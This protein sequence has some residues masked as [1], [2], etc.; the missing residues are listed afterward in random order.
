MFKNMRRNFT[1]FLSASAVVLLAASLAACSHK[2]FD[3]KGVITDAKDSVLYFENVGLDGPVTLDSVKLTAEGDFNFNEKAT[4]APEFYRLRIAGQ[5]INIAIDS[6]ETVEVKAA[7]PT[8]ATQYDVSGS[9]EN[10]KVKELALLQASLQQQID[11]I[12][13][14]PALGVEAVADSVGRVLA[15]YKDHIKRAYIYKEPMKAYA[16]FAL[17][18]T[19]T[20]GGTQSLIFDPRANEEDV[21]AFGAVATSWDTYYPKAVRGQ[22]LHNIA[23]EGMKNIRIIRAKMNQTLDPGRIDVSGVIDLNLQDNHGVYRRLSSLKGSVVLLDFHLFADKNS[24]KRIMKLREIYNKYHAQGLEIYQVS[25][26]PDEHFWKTQVAALPW[27][28]V[29]VPDDDTSALVK[30][31]VQGVPT[32]YLLNKDCTVYKRD[33]QMKDLEAEIKSLL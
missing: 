22:N 11:A 14:S 19:F 15:A 17:F 25:V 33:A 27:V 10:T 1:T 20:L 32:F 4:E 6:T 9:E 3:V 29:R 2:K 5:I 8:M 24:I 13:N 23:I 7:Y 28:S 26:D 31:N 21:K 30:Y 12:A 18:Q 16:Y